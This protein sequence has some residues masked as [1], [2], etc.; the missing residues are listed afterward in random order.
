MIE[1][2]KNRTIH[3]KIAGL[4]LHLNLIHLLNNI[5]NKKLKLQISVI[6]IIIIA[7]I[8]IA[9]IILLHYSHQYIHHSR[10][11]LNHMP[12]HH[13]ILKRTYSLINIQERDYGMLMWVKRIED[14]KEIKRKRALMNMGSIKMLEMDIIVE[15]G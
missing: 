12:N 4:V 5:F 14:M 13:H 1:M 10:I 6:I 8:I 11:S 15:D 9:I 7:M 2:R 3:M